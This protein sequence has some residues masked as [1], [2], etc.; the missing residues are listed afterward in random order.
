MMMYGGGF[1]LSSLI[2]SFSARAVGSLTQ[3]RGDLASHGLPLAMYCHRSSYSRSVVQLV[4]Q[5]SLEAKLCYSRFTDILLW[6]RDCVTGYRLYGGTDLR[7]MTLVEVGRRSDIRAY[8]L[9]GY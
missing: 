1:K 6:K 9:R 8:E 7:M 4:G 2:F 3:W 5:S